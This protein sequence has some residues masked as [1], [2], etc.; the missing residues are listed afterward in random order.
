MARLDERD[1][2]VVRHLPLRVVVRLPG[3]V[4]EAANEEVLGRVE[5]DDAVQGVSPC[6]WG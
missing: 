2:P 3:W 1:S 6:G 5:Q 4:V